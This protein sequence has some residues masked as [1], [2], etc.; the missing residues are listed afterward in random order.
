ML[1]ATG[2]IQQQSVNMSCQVFVLFCGIE[3]KKCFESYRQTGAAMSGQ[4]LY[5]MGCVVSLVAGFV[6]FD[7]RI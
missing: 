6:L 4:S 3:N 1:K 2:G 7:K 5:N